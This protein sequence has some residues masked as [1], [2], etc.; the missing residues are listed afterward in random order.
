VR[1]ELARRPWLYWLFVAVCAAVVATT[2]A[3]AHSATLH[4]RDRWG[5]SVPVLVSTRALAA[6]APIRA[7]PQQYPQ[8]MVPADALTTLPP[9]ATAAHALAAGEVLVAADLTGADTVPR[10]WAVFAVTGTD[11]PTLAPGD[12]VALF[13]DGQRWCDGIVIRG[14]GAASGVANDTV[15]VAVPGDCADAV[16][17]QVAAGTVVLAAVGPAG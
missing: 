12:A 13:G 16:S 14:G 1:Y 8:A 7:S 4:E 15:E 10:G 2:L 9:G 11:A 17:L 3:T 6:G 5:T